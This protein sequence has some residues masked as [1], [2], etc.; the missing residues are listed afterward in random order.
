M[1]LWHWILVGI[2]CLRCKTCDHHIKNILGASFYMAVEI[3]GTRW[4]L[5]KK[6]DMLKNPNLHSPCKTTCFPA[7][8]LAFCSVPWGHAFTG[9]PSCWPCTNRDQ[10][11]GGLWAGNLVEMVENET[12]NAG[13]RVGLCSI[14]IHTEMQDLSLFA[15]AYCMV[16]QDQDVPSLPGS[17]TDLNRSLQ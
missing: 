16:Q 7:A 13:S 4:Q 6:Q 1:L 5:K 9:R 8:D 11:V 14:T 15:P 2:H 12:G 3:W 17:L 10:Q